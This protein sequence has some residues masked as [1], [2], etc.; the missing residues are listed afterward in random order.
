M[1]KALGKDSTTT[2]RAKRQ[3]ELGT[4]VGRARNYV[5]RKHVLEANTNYEHILRLLIPMRRNSKCCF[6]VENIS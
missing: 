2:D 1:G 3:D 6:G 4:D 5:L